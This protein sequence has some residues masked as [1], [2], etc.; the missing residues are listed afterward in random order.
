MMN[1]NFGPYGE[2]PIAKS[3]YLDIL[4]PRTVPSTDSDVQFEITPPYQNRPDLL[5]HDLYGSRQLWWVFAQRNPDVLIDPVYDF[6]AGTT[7]FLPRGD[8]LRSELGV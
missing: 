7:I 5:A 4:K 2:T 1:R 3:G 6:T 8:L